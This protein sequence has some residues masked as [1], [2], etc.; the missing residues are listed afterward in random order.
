M[1]RNL[2]RNYTRINGDNNKL[3]YNCLFMNDNLLFCKFSVLFIIGIGYFI[4]YFVSGTNNLAQ[5]LIL[6]FWNYI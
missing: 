3:L 4:I 6:H 2:H 1:E 5:S